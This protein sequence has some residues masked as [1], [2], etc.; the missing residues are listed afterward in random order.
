MESVLVPKGCKEKY[1]FCFFDTFHCDLLI[2]QKSTFLA[3]EFS[4]GSFS[5]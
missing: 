4:V 1:G 5:E 3:C 2:M